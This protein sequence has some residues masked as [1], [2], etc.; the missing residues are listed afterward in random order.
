MS[1]GPPPVA[2]R[3][4]APPALFVALVL[5]IFSDGY[6]YYRDELYFAMLKPAWGYVDQPPLSPLIAHGLASLYD[7]GPWLVRIPATL[8]AAACLVL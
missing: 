7:G 5:S 1:G 2:W 6:G 8:S 4:I 3:R